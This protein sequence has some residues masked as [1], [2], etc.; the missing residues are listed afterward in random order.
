MYYILYCFLLKINNNI[1]DSRLFLSYCQSMGIPFL[2]KDFDLD[3]KKCG[4][5]DYV[6]NLGLLKDLFENHYV[7]YYYI[8]IYIFLKK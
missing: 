1:K 5:R 2:V 3:F 6:D 8:Y 7:I 4:L